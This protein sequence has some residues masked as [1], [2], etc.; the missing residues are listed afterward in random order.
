MEMLNHKLQHPIIKSER[1]RE[2]IIK[3]K[4]L[5]YRFN[6]IL[7]NLYNFFYRGGL[8]YRALNSE[9]SLQLLLESKKSL[10]RLG[11]GES[12]ILVG[13]DMATQVYDKGLRN[14]LLEIIK[15]YNDDCHYLLGLTN[16][17]LTKSVKEL[18]STPNQSAFKIWRFMRFAFWKYRMYRITMPFLEADMFRIGQV[19]LKLEDIEKLWKNSSY[20]VMLLNNEAYYTWFQGR[21]KDKKVYFVK[22]PDKNFFKVLPEVQN[23][24]LNLIKEQNIKEDNVV[25]LAAAGPGAKVLCYNLCQKDANYLCYDMGNFFHMHYHNFKN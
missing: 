23:K 13:L 10:I 19:G 20:I 18:K 11:N 14:T 22:I 12:E 9:E 3:K 1:P 24:I 16:W 7:T 15:S 21:Y 4:T 2:L 8:A 17:R 5:F 25:I 6:S